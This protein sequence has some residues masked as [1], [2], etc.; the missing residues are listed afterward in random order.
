MAAA[1]PAIGVV[2]IDRDADQI[3]AAQASSQASFDV[4]DIA[5]WQTPADTI[6]CVGATHAFGG[7][8]DA[9]STLAPRA[10]RQLIVAD[11]AWMGEPDDWCRATFGE[12]PT[13]DDVADTAAQ[14]GFASLDLSTSALDEWDEFEQGFIAGIRSVGGDDAQY[15]ADLRSEEYARYRGVLGFAWLIGTR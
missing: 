9:I 7:T 10:R 11:A 12:L 8:V 3:A 2:G 14:I 5:A 6:V 1:A 13:V 15:F 4:G